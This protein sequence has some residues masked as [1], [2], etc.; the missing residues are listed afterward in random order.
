MTLG[1]M[2]SEMMKL[3]KSKLIF[4]LFFNESEKD[5]RFLNLLAVIIREQGMKRTVG[6][7]RLSGKLVKQMLD[8]SFQEKRD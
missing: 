6:V 8:S 7:Y 3:M 2:Y 1:D 5:V 4:S